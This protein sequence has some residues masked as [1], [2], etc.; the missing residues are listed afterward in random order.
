MPFLRIEIF[1]VVT[2]AVG[3][4]AARSVLSFVLALLA[5]VSI[6]AQRTTLNSTTVAQSS[7]VDLG[8][9]LLGIA[10]LVLPAGVAALCVVIRGDS[11]AM[12]GLSRE[13][14]RARLVLGIVAALTIGAVGLG[15]YLLAYHLGLSRAVIPTTL[16]SHWWRI[17]ILILSALANAIVE[18]VVL[19]G[20]LG[21][22]LRQCGFSAAGIV[23]SS[24][25]LRALYHIY[26]GMS[27]LLGNF[28][29]GALFMSYF[30]RR[31]SVVALITAHA[32]ID[33]IAF[34]GYLEL[35]PRVEWL[36]G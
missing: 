35:A 3:I 5:P 33:I 8:F 4:A 20:Y 12:I 23:T 34:I 18:E 15:I 25:I 7:W 19:I 10:A 30:Q 17:P 6:S 29:M 11:L 22:R 28:I 32:V 26:Q 14:L 31:G 13:R 24:A 36:P 1:L 21:Y 2:L 9:Q 27:G 16:A